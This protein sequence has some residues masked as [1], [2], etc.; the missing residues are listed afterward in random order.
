MKLEILLQLGLLISKFYS[1]FHFSIPLGYCLK[2]ALHRYEECLIHKC[3][4]LVIV[5]SQPE[6][7]L[8]KLRNM[9]I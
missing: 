4:A 9:Y 2:L 1:A 6:E 5:M 8:R 7:N 3:G